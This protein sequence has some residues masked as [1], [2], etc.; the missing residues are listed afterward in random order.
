MRFGG[1]GSVDA[2]LHSLA[3]YAFEAQAE[4]V[5]D[6]GVHDRAELCEYVF[7]R[8]QNSSAEVQPIGSDRV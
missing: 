4:D 8:A 6:I 3:G 7:R 1:F 5:L 2:E